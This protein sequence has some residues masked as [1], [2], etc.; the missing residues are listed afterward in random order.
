MSLALEINDNKT[1]WIRVAIRHYS[2]S[3][4][5]KKKI[6]KGETISCDNIKYRR[7]DYLERQALRRA[8]D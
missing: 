8:L 3:S 6:L 5:Q 2:F 1:G 4:D 7:V